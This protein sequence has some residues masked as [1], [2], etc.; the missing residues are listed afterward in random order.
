MRIDAADA[1]ADAVDLVGAEG[2]ASGI[3]TMDGETA[4]ARCANKRERLDWGR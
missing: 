4:G 3:E 1:D 2:D